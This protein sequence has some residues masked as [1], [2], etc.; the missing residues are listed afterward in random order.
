M[1]RKEFLSQVGIGVAALLAPACIGGLSGC[2]KNTTA[3]KVDFTINTSTGTLAKNGGFLVSNS[4]IVA[5]TNAG[6]FIAVAAACTHQGTTVNYNSTNDVFV[7]PNHNAIFSE[8][9]S[10]MQGPATIN[11]TKYNTTLTGTS[12][13]VFS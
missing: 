1:D 11:L 12:L 2:K 13:R 3:T 9:G 7:C 10:V 5:R 6:A 8:N 4:V